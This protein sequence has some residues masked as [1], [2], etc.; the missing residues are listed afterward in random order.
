[1]QISNQIYNLD[2]DRYNFTDL[3]LKMRDQYGDFAQGRQPLTQHG[4]INKSIFEISS[5]D[6]FTV[7]FLIVKLKDSHKESSWTLSVFQLPFN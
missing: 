7:W 5:H 4:F 6:V 2:F 1:M 3:N